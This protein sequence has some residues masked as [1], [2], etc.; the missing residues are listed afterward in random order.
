[1][2]HSFVKQLF[3]NALLNVWFIEQSRASMYSLKFNSK[4]SSFIVASE[5]C[6][7]SR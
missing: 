4:G 5:R 7:E 1:M 3:A 2:K 6:L